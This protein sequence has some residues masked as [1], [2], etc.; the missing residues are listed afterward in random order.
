M[1][2]LRWELLPYKSYYFEV[3]SSSLGLGH[4]FYIQCILKKL[5]KKE[6]FAV[7]LFALTIPSVGIEIP[8]SGFFWHVLKTI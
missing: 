2:L 6:A 7:C 1:N 4:S 8:S 3:G 5:G